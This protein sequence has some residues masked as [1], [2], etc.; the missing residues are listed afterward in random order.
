MPCR[1]WLEGEKRV[2]MAEEE[3]TLA[4]CVYVCDA[5]TIKEIEFN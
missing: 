4:M 5:R 3:N 1:G 2:A